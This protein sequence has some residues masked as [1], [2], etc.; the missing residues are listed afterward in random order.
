MAIDPE[1][2]D[3]VIDE[4]A[5]HVTEGGHT[6]LIGLDTGSTVRMGR[7]P[8]KVRKQMSE[9]QKNMT[10]LSKEDMI[11]LTY[12]EVSEHLTDLKEINYGSTASTQA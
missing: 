11:D 7:I 12:G 8:D 6:A 1:D 2:P 10:F 4:M 9:E 3:S 5:T